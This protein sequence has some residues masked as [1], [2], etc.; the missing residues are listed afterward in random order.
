MP[1]ALPEC[2]QSDGE[3]DLPAPAQLCLDTRLTLVLMFGRRTLTHCSFPHN[4]FVFHREKT[5]IHS[6]HIRRFGK[7]TLLAGSSS[8]SP[9]TVEQPQSHHASSPITYRALGIDQYI[10]Q[11]TCT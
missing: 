8:S 3:Q 10:L 11:G 2:I 9:H 6:E 7:V 1:G 4:S 5:G